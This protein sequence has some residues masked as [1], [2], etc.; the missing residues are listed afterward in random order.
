MFYRFEPSDQ[1]IYC[2]S[3]DYYENSTQK[4]GDEHIFPLSLSGDWIFPNASCRACE[5]ITGRIE[6]ILLNG[7]LLQARRALGLKGRTKANRQKPTFGVFDDVSGQTVKVDIAIDQNPG[8]LILPR[9]GLPPLMNGIVGGSPTLEELLPTPPFTM[10]LGDFHSARFRNANGL[11]HW[12][13]PDID[14]PLFCRFLA[15]VA[16]S[17]ATAFLG[18]TGFHR[19]LPDILSNPDFRSR[20][21]LPY[22][23]MH[24]TYG[25]FNSLNYLG[26]KVVRFEGFRLIVVEVGLFSGLGAPIYWVIV[27]THLESPRLPLISNPG[28]V[29]KIPYQLRMQHVSD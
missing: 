16:H 5:R 8:L 25:P 17:Y 15:K 12:S 27:G 1:C 23:G 18:V 10:V 22:V 21:V 26:I 24:T 3:V 13:P 2:G 20:D 7:F 4:L 9:F 6:S 11:G 14:V 29:D 28:N 19:T